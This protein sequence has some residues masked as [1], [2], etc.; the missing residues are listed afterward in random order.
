MALLEVA[1]VFVAAINAGD[2]EKLA[3]LMT[4]NHIFVDAD[5][6]EHGAREKMKRGWRE[7]FAMVPDFRIRVGRT[8]L[9][10]C[11]NHPGNVFRGRVRRG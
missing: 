6:S 8:G 4:P 7:Y 9:V 1:D 5:G 11:D 3:N 2:V 10:R